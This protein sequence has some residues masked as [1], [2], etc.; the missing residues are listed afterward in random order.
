MFRQTQRILGS[1]LIILILFG[2]IPSLFADEG[3][4]DSVVIWGPVLGM[5]DGRG[6]VRI[7]A[8]MPIRAALKVNG[9]L[10]SQD[11]SKLSHRQELQF[12][13]NLVGSFSYQIIV[14]Y[15]FDDRMTLGPYKARLPGEP[16]RKQRFVVYGDNRGESPVHYEI[17]RRILDSDP[18][19]VLN[20]GDLVDDGHEWVDWQTFRRTTGEL[21]AR[22]VLI[23]CLGNH[24]KRSIHYFEAFHL[25]GNEAWFEWNWEPLKVLVLD[26]NL[27]S[28]EQ[29][30]QTRWLTEQLMKSKKDGNITLVMFHHPPM[31]SGRHRPWKYGL[32]QWVPLIVSQS[33]DMV[34]LGHNHLYERL[35]HQGTPF[36]ITGGGGA[37]L[38]PDFER[39]PETI[40][41]EAVWH[42]VVIQYDGNRVVGEAIRHDGSTI[43]QWEYTPKH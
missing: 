19:F 31:G 21:M 37:P 39:I 10:V 35:E 32:E 43:E 13:E 22:R 20:T 18:D 40:T 25:P 8:K 33:V 12:P 38:Y 7:D 2:C 9:K 11:V 6:S 14:R 4:P 29:D 26:S 41:V 30:W 36:I 16:G 27:P 3:S 1:Y 5:V 34:L 15:G 23:P 17:T 42:F 28:E 24:D